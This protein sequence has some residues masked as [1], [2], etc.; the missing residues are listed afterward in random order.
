MSDERRAMRVREVGMELL[1]FL[2]A[3]GAGSLA[4]GVRASGSI[5]AVSAWLVVLVVARHVTSALFRRYRL[6]VIERYE[7]ICDEKFPRRNA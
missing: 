6:L 1:L 3:A 2:I 7:N 4:Y 5:L